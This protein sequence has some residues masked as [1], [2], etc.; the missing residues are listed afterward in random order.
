LTAQGPKIAKGEREEAS[1]DTRTRTATP[2]YT[3]I[4]VALNNSK[5][6]TR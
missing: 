5:R 4:T 6:R 1:R 3:R 2:T